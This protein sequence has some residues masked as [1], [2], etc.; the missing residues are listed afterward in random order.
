MTGDR[1]SIV[2]ITRMCSCSSSHPYVSLLSH[3]SVLTIVVASSSSF[4]FMFSLHFAPF[5]SVFLS[6]FSLYSVPSVLRSAGKEAVPLDS[7]PW[8]PGGNAS[9]VV[10]TAA[11]WHDISQRF[12][13]V[14]G[15]TAISFC[16]FHPLPLARRKCSYCDSRCLWYVWTQDLLYFQAEG[17]REYFC[18]LVVSAFYGHVTHIFERLVLIWTYQSVVCLKEIVFAIHFLI[19]NRVGSAFRFSLC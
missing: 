3:S 9:V 12:R 4:D 19:V 13:N 16:L 18:S 2:D 5:P 8:T 11:L 6:F 14:Q 7:R 1:S 15:F 10:G 17:A